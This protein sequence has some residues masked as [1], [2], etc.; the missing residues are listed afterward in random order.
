MTS[1]FWLAALC[2]GTGCLWANRI[3]AQLEVRGS[4]THHV[5]NSIE[6]RG[7]EV[8][9]N[10]SQYRAKDGSYSLNKTT[11]TRGTGENKK[12]GETEV[13][14]FNHDD[15]RDDDACVVSALSELAAGE[16]LE[17][18][19]IE[20]PPVLQFLSWCSGTTKIYKCVYDVKQWF[21]VI[22]LSLHISSK[23][24]VVCI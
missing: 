2:C 1:W 5:W 13:N 22:S 10:H 21:S 16:D 18:P 20:L 8:T 4:Q 24:V 15:V 6:P 12:E 9:L 17:S 7:S 11:W 14:D 19:R 23:P 3:R